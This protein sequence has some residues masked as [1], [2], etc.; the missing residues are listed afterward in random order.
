[1]RALA[2]FEPGKSGVFLVF[3]D[4][5]PPSSGAPSAWKR[6][7]WYTPHAGD[8]VGAPYGR[9]AFLADGATEG[10][11]VVENWFELLDSWYDPE[12]TRPGGVNGYR[13]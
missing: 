9:W 11:G 5:D 2:G 1:M 10:N 4:G 12:S 7:L 3:P 13:W 6:F 8:D